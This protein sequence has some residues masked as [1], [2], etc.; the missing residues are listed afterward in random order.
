MRKFKKMEKVFEL[1]LYDY[2]S[3]ETSVQHTG[4]CENNPYVTG[5]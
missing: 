4:L 2:E 3:L 1:G 5:L